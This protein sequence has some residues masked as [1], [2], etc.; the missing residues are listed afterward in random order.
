MIYNEFKGETLSHLGFGAMRLP[1]DAD[2][3]VD[4]AQVEQMVRYALAHGVNYFD[5][6]YPYHG[7]LSETVLCRILNTY[8]RNSFYLADKYPGHQICK[9][10]DPA[11]TFE[12]QLRKCRVDYFDFYLLHNVCESS[13]DTYTDP[14]WNII[15]YFVEQRRLGRIRHL[16][17]SSHAEPRALDRFLDSYAWAMEFCQIQLNYVDWTLQ[18]AREKCDILQAHHIPI[19]VME[20]LRGG[21]LAV[22]EAEDRAA[23]DKFRPGETP[24]TW[25]FRWLQGKPG[26][27]VILSG[28]SNLE[29]MQQNIQTFAAQDPLSAEETGLLEGIAT[30]LGKMVPCTGCRYCCDGCPQGLDIPLM[31]ATLSDAR[32]QPSFTP[33]MRMEFLPAD[34]QPSA[35]IGCGAC[36]RICPQHIDIPA[37]MKELC[38]VLQEIPNWRELSRQR[39]EAAARLRG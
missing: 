22:L 1:V 10:Y 4:E 7:G 33:G 12:E 32:F 20:P 3:K 19:W 39:E 8:P 6:A 18:R 29:Q 13:M 38:R 2:G 21:K 23:L 37:A 24:A 36:A 28:M 34:K 31:M 17:F 9:A 14:R 5:T 30:R 25:A 35:C 26:V 11:Y 15:P 16:G 27:K